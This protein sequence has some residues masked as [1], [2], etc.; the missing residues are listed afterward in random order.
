V[1]TPLGAVLAHLGAGVSDRDPEVNTYLSRRMAGALAVVHRAIARGEL[2]AGTD[3]R[4][5]VYVAMGPVINRCFYGP[6]PDDDFLDLV[7][8]MLTAGLPV[9]LAEQPAKRSSGRSAPR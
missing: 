5:V 3:P 1:S 8:A 2:P 4:D 9:A 6:R 7:V